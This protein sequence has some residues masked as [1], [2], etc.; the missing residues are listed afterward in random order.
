M[1]LSFNATSE[2]LTLTLLD[3]TRHPHET[4][5]TE[6]GH[7][8]HTLMNRLPNAFLDLD[9]HHILS[10]FSCGATE[11]VCS[12]TNGRERTE[13]V[14]VTFTM[15]AQ[16][17]GCGELVELGLEEALVLV[18][19][20]SLLTSACGPMA[21]EN[22]SAMSQNFG[23][24]LVTKSAARNSRATANDV[25]KLIVA[26]SGLHCTDGWRVSRLH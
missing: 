1:H 23:T 4:N 26:G 14:A 16:W 8:K 20:F 3:N 10:V 2:Y 9:T 25:R 6:D 24:M 12:V 17:R 7:N 19:I 11:A 21:S 22:D 13:D 18:G 15:T 5:Q